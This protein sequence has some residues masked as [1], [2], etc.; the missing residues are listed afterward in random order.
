MKALGAYIKKNQRHPKA[1]RENGIQGQVLVR[2]CINSLGYVPDSTVRVLRGIG[3][4]CD[5]E[6][7][8]LV[9][10][11]RRWKPATA[12]GKPYAVIYHIPILFPP[13]P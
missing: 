9:R 6:A 8:R 10:C 13:R 1:A 7:V 2:F 5:E 4:G 12:S 11:M 3:Y